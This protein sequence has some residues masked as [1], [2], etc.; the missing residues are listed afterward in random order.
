[1][2][3]PRFTDVCVYQCSSTHTVTEMLVNV[4]NIKEDAEIEDEA[5][6]YVYNIMMFSL[7]KFYL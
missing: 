7:L 3:S 6:I 5:G 2:F 1:M 4:L